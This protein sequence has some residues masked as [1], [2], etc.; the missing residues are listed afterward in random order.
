MNK[1]KFFVGVFVFLF[2]IFLL[3]FSFNTITGNSI[4]SLSSILNINSI[5]GLIFILGGLF[6]MVTGNLE[7]KIGGERYDGVIILG[8]NWKGYPYKLKPR[9]RGEKEFLDISFRSKMNCVTAAEMYKEG[10]A[11][12]II[13]GTGQSAGKKWPSEA[14]A[15]KNYILR[16]YKGI[17]REDILTHEKTLDTY[18]EIDE[19]LKLA[20]E[21]G[22]INLVLATVNTQLPRARKYLESKG[23]HL[24]YISSEEVFKTLGRQHEKLAEGYA[25]SPAVK[26]Y[27]TFKEFVLRSMQKLGITGG[28]TKPLAK[29]IRR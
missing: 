3:R 23:E 17:S 7:K 8:G 4:L 15:M 27:E 10:L 11:R 29:L 5:V 25:E 12:K 1:R 14:Q 18:D 28:F 16:K 2:G 13:I 21:N 19:D 6:L 9:K 22:L 26:Y 24:G 20:R